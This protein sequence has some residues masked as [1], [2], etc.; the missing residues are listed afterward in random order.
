MTTATEPAGASAFTMPLAIEASDIVKTVPG[1]IANDHVDFDVR[2]GEIHALLGENGAGKSTL[3]NVLAGLYRPEGG[4]V[5]VGGRPVDFRSPR[6]AI[7]AGIGMVHQHFTLVPSM[8]VAE[9]VLLGLD[10]PRFR[11]DLPRTEQQVANLAADV[12]LR[13]DPRARVWQL[14]V[15]EQQ[16]VEILK[17]LF[18][19]ARIL[20]L[21]EPTAVLAPQETAELFATL[22]SM[23]EAGRS[24]VF[25]SHKLAEV[26]AIADRITVMRGGT[27]TAAG[28]DAHGVTRSELARRMV[29]RP[30]IELPERS[31]VAPGRVVLTVDDVHALNDRGL[32]ALQGA[33]FEVRA[34]EIVGIAAV[35]GNGQSEL[36]EVITGLRPCT[37]HVTVDGTAVGDRPPSVANEAGVSHVPEDRTGVGSAPNLSMVDNLILRRFRSAPLS[38]GPFMDG[39]AART[40]AEELRGAYAISAPTIDSP[41][42]ILSGGN[43]QRLILAREIDAAP[44]L[45][46]A[47]QPTRG[48]DVGAIEGVHQLLLG[49]RERG[50]ATLLVSEELEEL[51]ALADRVIVMYEGRI[52]G[53]FEAPGPD[54]IDQIGLL[55]TG[56]DEPAGAARAAGPDPTP[57]AADPPPTEPDA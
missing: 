45:L 29:G 21:D 31:P 16:R 56:G 39:G 53:T 41:A 27:V 13:V 30:V 4:T 1:V 42:R 3:M 51:L 34:G 10:T 6:D 26:L 22:R 17:M 2:V 55:M 50:T 18:H 11:L 52:A 33:S 36:A 19:G 43:L 7:A 48:L 57:P 5:K 28:I 40:K 23:L 24:V 32:P 47:V 54:D 49:L 44:T 8:T 15:G 14:S 35:A 46:V 12:G 37:G 20:I 38:H 9:N 25:C